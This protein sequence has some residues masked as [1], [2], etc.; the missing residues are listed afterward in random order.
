M[1]V[2][3]QAIRSRLRGQRK[4]LAAADICDASTAV[5]EQ[6][7]QLP[8]FQR[9][10]SVAT[11]IATENEVDPAALV[12]D[13][14]QSARSLYLPR[15]L[16]SPSWV[17]WEPSEPLRKGRFGVPEPTSEQPATPATP[18]LAL[19]PLVAW[20]VHGTRIGRGAGFYDRLLARPNPRPTCVGLAYEFQ[21]VEELPR[22]AWDVPLDYVITERRVVRCKA[23]KRSDTSQK[24]GW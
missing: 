14:S 4:L 10:A 6:V 21:E 2:D 8:A 3:K 1:G 24:G 16:E 22:E 9:A 17:A 23:A 12:A 20:D 19:V 18:L 7:R 15:Q 11:Y 13:V 5:C